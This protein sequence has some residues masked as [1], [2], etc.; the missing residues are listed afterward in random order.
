[1]TRRG[2]IVGGSSVLLAGTTWKWLTSRSNDRLLPW[3]LR[4]VLEADEKVGR[5]LFD[6]KKLSP[7][8][9][10]SLVRMPKVNGRIGID[11]KIDLDR[12][13]LEVL[14]P[15]GRRS[16][17]LADIKAFPRFEMT[18]ELRCVEG[19]SEIVTWA[20]TRLVDLAAST[21]LAMISGKPG[22]PLANPNDLLP[23][24]SLLTPNKQYYVGLDMPSALHPQTLLCYEMNGAPLT[25][26][27]GAPLRLSIP[28][29]YGIK[30]LKQVGTLQFTSQRP[31]DYWAQLGYDWYA[32]H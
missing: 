16:L 22:D 23:F 8:F 4:R 27:H 28:I 17:S 3:P 15:S 20:G 1:M 26:E 30:S 19:W 21:G 11:K 6:P 2:L 12:W 18:T 29:K 10:T 32:G 24:V 31:A 13:Q 25:I 9:P 5:A 7:S 14:G